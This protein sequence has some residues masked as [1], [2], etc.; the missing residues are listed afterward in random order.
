MANQK[1][2]ALLVTDTSEQ[3]KHAKAVL[4][5]ADVNYRDET[6]NV[7]KFEK[8]YVIAREGNFLGIKRIVQFAHIVYNAAK[9]K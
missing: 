5:T 1:I 6:D 9:P 4:E 3:S 8:P 7:S 2:E